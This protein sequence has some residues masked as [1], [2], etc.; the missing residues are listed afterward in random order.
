MLASVVDGF[1]NEISPRRENANVVISNFLPKRL[2]WRES[3]FVFLGISIWGMRLIIKSPSFLLFLIL[4][5][6]KKCDAFCIFMILFQIRFFD[7]RDLILERKTS[8]QTFFLADLKP[9]D[10]KKPNVRSG[11]FLS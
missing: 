9:F 1:A 2:Y 5:K 8:S 3:V 10:Q 4:T 11:L 7:G 6:E